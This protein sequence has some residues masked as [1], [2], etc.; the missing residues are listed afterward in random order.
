MP[1][2]VSFAASIAKLAHREKSC[3][4]SLNQSITRPLTHPGYLMPWKPKL[5]L[6]NNNTVY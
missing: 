2:F 5:V 6:R 1:N 4:H 3:T